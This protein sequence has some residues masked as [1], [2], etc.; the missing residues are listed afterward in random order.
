MRLIDLDAKN[1]YLL[2]GRYAIGALPP[3]GRLIDGD[4]AKEELRRAEALTKAFGYHNVIATIIAQ[5][6]VI[7]A[8]EATDD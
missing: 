4:R 2:D 7:E 3:H 1:P 8:E 6:T 5:P